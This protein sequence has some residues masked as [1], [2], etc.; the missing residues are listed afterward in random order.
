MQALSQ[1]QI[2]PYV[3]SSQNARQQPPTT[4]LSNTQFLV[5]TELFQPLKTIAVSL[6]NQECEYELIPPSS[7]EDYF[8]RK[9]VVDPYNDVVE[10]VTKALV[11]PLDELKDL[12][13]RYY[14]ALTL[15]GMSNK[16]KDTEF[17]YPLGDTNYIVAVTKE[18]FERFMETFATPKISPVLM[19][20]ILDTQVTKAKT[21]WASFL[22]WLTSVFGVT[23]P[24]ENSEL[25]NLAGKKIT[26]HFINK[27][28]IPRVR[29]LKMKVE[30][31]E[32]EVKDAY[33]NWK[34]SELEKSLKRDIDLI[35]K[36]VTIKCELLKR[37]I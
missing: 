14:M 20:L 7:D 28:T 35:V 17:V 4:P 8:H 37:I 32:A 31:L 30:R 18:L 9:T 2:P 5:N 15:E 19:T 10:K 3:P 6:W 34:G 21:V 26:D 11:V 12:M 25:E 24:P 29:E 33:G 23:L 16:K 22:R 27:G 13:L 36:A 1:H